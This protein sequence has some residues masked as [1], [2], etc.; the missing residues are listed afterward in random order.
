MNNRFYTIPVFLAAGLTALAGCD[1]G[2]G[3]N[4]GISEC[5][6]FE[7]VTRAIVRAADECEDETLLLTVDA[8]DEVVHF[9]HENA[10]FNCCGDHSITVDRDDGVYVV[11][12]IDEPEGSWGL[13]GGSRCSCTCLFDFAVD[14]PCSETGVISLRVDQIVTDE[15]DEPDTVWHGDIDLSQGIADVVIRENVDYCWDGTE[16]E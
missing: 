15:S 12:E 4:S 11:T 6:G 1:G 10:S 8:E 13:F 5:G 3:F 7:T 16:T 9:L 14:F 2:I